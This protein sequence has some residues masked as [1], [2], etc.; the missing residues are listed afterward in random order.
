MLRLILQNTHDTSRMLVG[1]FT[2][3]GQVTVVPT[4]KAYLNEY[5]NAVY[6]LILSA[7]LTDFSYQFIVYEADGNVVKSK[8]YDVRRPCRPDITVS[9]VDA[10][11]ITDGLERVQVLV[12]QSRSLD[13]EARRYERALEL[14]AE[15]EELLED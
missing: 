8:R 9:T 14:V 3:D 12:Q 11:T 2:I 15:L 4:S 7:P 10:A 1:L 5:D 6:E 13:S